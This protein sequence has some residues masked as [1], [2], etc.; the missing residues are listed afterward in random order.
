LG[1]LIPAR[2]GAF[3][4]ANKRKGMAGAPP[5]GQIKAVNWKVNFSALVPNVI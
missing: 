1:L 4:K 5:G 2:D 3:A